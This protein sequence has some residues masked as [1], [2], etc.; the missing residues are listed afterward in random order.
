MASGKGPA[1]LEP[2]SVSSTNAHDFNVYGG[3][4]CSKGF[5]HPAAQLANSAADL[6]G[7]GAPQSRDGSP[8]VLRDNLFPGT[9]RVAVLRT[10]RPSGDGR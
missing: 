10:G 1:F 2:S 7:R 4:S 5:L 3:P 6:R 9:F 8:H